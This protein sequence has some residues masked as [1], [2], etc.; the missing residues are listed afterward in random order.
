MNK[1]IL[2]SFMIFIGIRCALSAGIQAI[3]ADGKKM[4]VD[5]LLLRDAT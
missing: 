2:C 5:D 1:Y 4:D 3:I